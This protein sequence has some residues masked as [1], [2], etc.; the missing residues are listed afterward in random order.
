MAAIGR[1]VIETVPNELFQTEIFPHL[2][3][4]ILAKIARVSKRFSE[5]IKDTGSYENDLLRYSNI[6][7]FYLM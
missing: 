2:P 3:W 1:S 5:L 7:L 6:L 4:T